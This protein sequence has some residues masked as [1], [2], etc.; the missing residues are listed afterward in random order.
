M[1]FFFITYSLKILLKYCLYKAKTL[2]SV[3]A[4]IVD[5]LGVPYRSANYPKIYPDPYV[6]TSY[7]C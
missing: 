4:I 2:P 5:A 7:L 6:L 1:A 3:A